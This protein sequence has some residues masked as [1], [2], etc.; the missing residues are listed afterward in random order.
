M[1]TYNFLGERGAFGIDGCPEGCGVWLD[2]SELGKAHV[3]LKRVVREEQ[4]PA[5][6]KSGIIA[7]IIAV[8]T[9]R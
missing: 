4:V 6:P 9:V 3:A 7:S 1:S 8:M 5:P 2:D